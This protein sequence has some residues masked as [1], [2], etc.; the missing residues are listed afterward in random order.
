MSA[1]LDDIA[2]ALGDR[3]WSKRADA[4]R[5]LTARL[6]AGEISGEEELVLVSLLIAATSDEKWEVQK[7]AAVALSEL[8]HADGALVQSRLE[9]L[10]RGQQTHYVK[11]AAERALKRIRS[12]TQRQKEWN[13]ADQTRDPTLQ[14]IMT[15][16]REIGLRSMTPAHI[17]DLAMEVS[18]QSYREVAADTAHELRNILTPFE[19]YL[20]QL[21]QRLSDGDADFEETGS[22]IALALSRLDHITRLVDDIG[23]Y[24]SPTAAD[25]SPTSL[26]VLIRE[27]VAIGADR[28]EHGRGEIVVRHVVDVPGAIVIDALAERL[29]R[30]IT[31]LIANA[32]QAMETE[33]TLTIRALISNGDRVIL[34]IEDTGKG[35]TPEDVER[36]R[37][38]FRSTR[39]GDGGTGLG[40]PIAERIIVEDHRG[41]IEIDSTPRVGTRVTITLPLRQPIGVE[42]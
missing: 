15:R 17:Y 13:L 28:G 27:A 2:G 30:A 32:Y 29:L 21:R 24:S 41:E 10:A 5:L 19:G 39:R 25:F 22:L 7:A 34:T 16:I 35:M 36:A 18:E 42:Q 38:R 3:S 26:D 9:A 40:L 31:N 4:L 8:R 20:V 1:R 33:G 6:A 37:V 11:E 14:H 12:R 23:V